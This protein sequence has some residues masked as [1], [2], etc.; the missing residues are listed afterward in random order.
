MNIEWNRNLKLHKQYTLE[1]TTYKVFIW[2]NW[3]KIKT[4]LTA[5]LTPAKHIKMTYHSHYN[6]DRMAYNSDTYTGNSNSN[7]NDYNSSDNGENN[8]F[9][10]VFSCGEFDD[11]YFEQIDR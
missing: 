5:T 3:T 8:S 1:G 6:K 9:I 11:L 2:R 4:H 7:I 10:S